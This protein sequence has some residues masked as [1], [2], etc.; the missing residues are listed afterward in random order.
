MKKTTILA[1]A[2]GLALLC[3]V[4]VDLVAKEPAA[5]DRAEKSLQKQA[6]GTAPAAAASVKTADGERS[7]KPRTAPAADALR[8]LPNGCQGIYWADVAELRKTTPAWLKKAFGPGLG[9]RP[10]TST[11]LRLARPCGRCLP[12][13]DLF[14]SVSHSH[15]LWRRLVSHSV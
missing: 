12:I 3:L 8:Y 2:L 10:K 14:N 9:V 13:G 6:A 5:K 7:D 4:R 11:A 1:V 15:A